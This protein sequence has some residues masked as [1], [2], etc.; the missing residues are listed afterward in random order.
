VDLADGHIAA[1][2]KLFATP[3]IGTSIDATNTHVLHSINWLMFDKFNSSMMY[4]FFIF[5]CQVVWLTI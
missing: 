4:N 1:L 5:F 2:E 3:D